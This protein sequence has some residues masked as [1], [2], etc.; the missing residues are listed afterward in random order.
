MFYGD[1]TVGGARIETRR[2]VR[3]L[4]SW[5]KQEPMVTRKKVTVI[6]EKQSDVGYISNISQEDLL[7]D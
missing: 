5:S 1:Q 4:V 6:D 7:R 3:R 2:P